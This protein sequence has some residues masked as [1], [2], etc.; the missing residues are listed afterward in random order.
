MA[1]LEG[2]NVLFIIPRDY[3]SE[4]QLEPLQEIFQKEGANIYIASSKMK[5]AV[6]M[7]TGRVMPHLLIVDAIEGITGDSYVSGGR[8]VRQVKG[9]FHGVVVVGGRGARTYLWKDDLVRILL[10]DR[11]RSGFVVAAIGTAVPCLINAGVLD[12]DEVAADPDKKTVEALEK[13][14]FLLSEKPVTLLEHVLTASGPEGLP[15]FAE[16]FIQQVAQTP[17][18]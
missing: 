10:A 12:T 9:V 17:L 1:R 3:Y 16:E 11:H 13:G 7:K 2:K 14:K 4:E 6:G 5:E 8:G 18:K 15:E